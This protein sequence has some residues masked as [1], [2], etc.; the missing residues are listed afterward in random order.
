MNRMMHRIGLATILVAAVAP[1]AAQV[2]AQATEPS[3]FSPTSL[4]DASWATA[5]TVMPLQPAPPA[6]ASAAER[7]PAAVQIAAAVAEQPPAQAVVQ[8]S[9]ATPVP[10][11][12]ATVAPTPAPT[13]APAAA[14]PDLSEPSGPTLRRETTVV[15]EVVRIGDLVENAGA[16]AAVP[17][18]RAPDL[19]QTGSVP[20]AR[21][22]DAI[23]PHHIIWLNTRGLD[24]VLVTRASRAIAGKEIEARLLR[25]LGGQPGLSDLKDPAASF[26]N[27]VRPI[28]IEPNAELSIAR[29]A[30][31]PRTRRFDVAFDLPT[32]TGRRA[33]MRVTGTLVETVEA[34]V[35]VRAIA[36][37]DLLK[38]SDVVVE[39]RPK[40]EAAAVED[41]VGY[42]AKRAL[43]VGEVIRA[44]DVTKPELVGRN[45][46]VLIS[47]EAPGMVLSLRG[48]ALESGALGDVVN[49][50]NTQSKRT[51]HA[52]VS[53][54]GRV[55][56]TSA[57]PR[58]ASNANTAPPPR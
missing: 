40:T 12:L 34:A 58:L 1:L 41:V 33:A 3:L 24:E 52:T 32:S 28:Y 36:A 7:S 54:P 44:A 37:G 31:D 35:P 6:I 15:G 30:Y 43:R 18:F 2:G 9:V 49:V 45:E 20:A 17:I 22:L 10:T 16:V 13:P 26:D 11:P 51:L 57:V 5:D 46:T 29:L 48:K 25:A 4:A 39:R 14:L 21:V 23:R 42:A 8:E 27:E 56:V 38:A 55:T 19:G 53:G 50:L 47:F